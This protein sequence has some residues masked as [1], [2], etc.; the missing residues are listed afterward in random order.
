MVIFGFYTHYV[1][2]YAFSFI[3]LSLMCVGILQVLRM[4]YSCLPELIYPPH[5]LKTTPGIQ[6]LEIFHV[7]KLVYRSKQWHAFRNLLKV[8]VF[9]LINSLI[10]KFYGVNKT[11]TQLR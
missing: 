3:S 9:T 1:T 10:V 7:F 4:S 8:K 11:A 6:N 5:V 2:V